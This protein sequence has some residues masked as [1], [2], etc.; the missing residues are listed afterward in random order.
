MNASIELFS[1]RGFHAVSVRDIAR[2]VGINK[3]SIYN[4]Y[5]SKNEIMDVIIENFSHD[6]GSTFLIDSAKIEKQLEETGLETFLR[7]YIL[8]LNDRITADIQKIWKIIYIEMFIN[9]KIRD[10]FINVALKT[11]SQYYKELFMIMKKNGSI[12]HEDPSI[13]ADEFAYFIIGLQI[14]NLLL[15]TNNDDLSVNI[16][17]C[18]IT[19]NLF[20][21]S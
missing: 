14:E 7:M 20:A 21:I 3:S 11:S 13:L 1:Q 4:H 9:K 17:K 12:K 16:Q 18:T 5:K 8:N 15:Q 10:Y 2:K 6:F 19:S